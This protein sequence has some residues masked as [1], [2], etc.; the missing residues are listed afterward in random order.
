[1][2][3]CEY[4]RLMGGCAGLAMGVALGVQMPVIQWDGLDVTD[5]V[6]TKHI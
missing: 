3:L 5:P 4:Q 2:G 1:M 6:H